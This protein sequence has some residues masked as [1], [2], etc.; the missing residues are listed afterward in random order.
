[1]IVGHFRAI[2]FPALCLASNFFC[3]DGANGQTGSIDNYVEDSSARSEAEELF[4]KANE[5]YLKKDYDAV[6]PLLDRCLSLKENALGRDD[7]QVADLLLMIAGVYQEKGDS[8]RALPY[9]Q[10]SLGIKEKVFGKDSPEVGVTFTGLA[11]FTP[12][13]VSSSG[14]FRT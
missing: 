10:R 12:R 9:L 5:L 6:L 14:R 13:V 2:L 8:S 7:P 1:M 4:K 3:L 11:S